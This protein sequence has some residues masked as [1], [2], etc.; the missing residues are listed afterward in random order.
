MINGIINII[1]IG[2]ISI[3]IMDV[4]INSLNPTPKIQDRN[5]E[6]LFAKH[7]IKTRNLFEV[8]KR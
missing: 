7:I 5:E 6:K 8:Q 4:I 1:M 2:L 3:I